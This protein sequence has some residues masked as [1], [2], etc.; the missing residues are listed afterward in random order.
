MASDSSAIVPIVSF[1][2]ISNSDWKRLPELVASGFIGRAN[3]VICTH[4]DQVSQENMDEELKSVT[5]AFWPR[6][7]LNTNRVILCSLMGL[8]AGDL[9]DRSKNTLKP[10]FEAIWNKD[11]MGYRVRG[12][13]LSI[14]CV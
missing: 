4:T 1:E 13:V 12:P 9:L 10:P 7:V 6:G 11:S 8:S 3:V 14:A 2:E 5:T